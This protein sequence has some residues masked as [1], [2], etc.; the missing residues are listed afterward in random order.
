[1]GGRMAVKVATVPATRDSTGGEGMRTDLLRETRNG[2]RLYVVHTA[3]FQPKVRTYSLPR[4]TL[5][6]LLLGVVEG[7]GWGWR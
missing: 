1:M 4:R 3:A 2:D 6:Q 7:C 5:W